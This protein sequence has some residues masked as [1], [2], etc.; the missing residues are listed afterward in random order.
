MFKQAV[1]HYPT[2][3]NAVKQIAKDIATFRCAA[4]IKYIESLNWS[5]RQVEALYAS[6]TA[7][8][9]ARQQISA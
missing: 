7:D 1:I 5:D 6:I 4:T 8:I 3:E 9:T 2:D